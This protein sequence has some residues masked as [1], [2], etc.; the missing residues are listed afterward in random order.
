MVKNLKSKSAE[1]DFEWIDVVNPTADELNHL[2][3]QY[4]LHPVFVQDCLQPEHLPKYELM[5]DVAF[6][7]IRVYDQLASQ[8]ADT[9]QELTRKIAVFY[10][11]GFIITIHRTDQSVITEV[12]EKLVD[13]GKCTSM[14]HLL[15]KL[16]KSSLLTYEAPAHQLTTQLDFF[17]STVFLADTPRLM[18][19]DLYH[20]KRK[21]DVIKRLLLLSREI[22]DNTQRNTPYS[23]DIRD[24]LLKLDTMYD[25]MR[26][27]TSHLL[28]CYFSFTS[29]R[30]NEVMRVLTIFSVFF[31]PLTFIVGIYGMNFD[32]MP[33]LKMKYG[34]PVVMASMVFI[35]IGIFAWFKRKKWL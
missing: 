16:I 19:K 26:E 11:K 23:R 2:S 17:E 6:M 22:V 8:D 32:Y 3:V 7:I 4:N 14:E 24:C 25:S 9:I 5:D 27:N 35:I 30:T 31:M 13:A 29:Q 1:S 18:L 10:S 15:N 21:I 28:N 20:I 12:K 34:Y 33:E